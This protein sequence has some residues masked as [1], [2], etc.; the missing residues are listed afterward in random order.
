MKYASDFRKI[1]RSTL[2]GDWPVAIL[3]GFA[4]SVI[5]ANICE[6]GG[7]FNSIYKRAFSE[8]IDVFLQNDSFLISAYVF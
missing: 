4:A 3:T 2:H 1:A 8:K 5:G 6:A 7:S